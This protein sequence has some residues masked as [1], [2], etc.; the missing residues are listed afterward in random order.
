[1]AALVHSSDGHAL[2]ADGRASLL[3]TAVHSA[4]AK[5]ALEATVAAGQLSLYSDTGAALLGACWP[6]GASVLAAAGQ[7]VLTSPF[8][9][10]QL[11]VQIA[12]SATS[13]ADALGLTAD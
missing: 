3:S 6:G 12:L 7:L 5:D 9:P 4:S 1:M 10:A 11:V 13:T 8:G 2:A